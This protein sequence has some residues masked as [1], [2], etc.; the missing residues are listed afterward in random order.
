M[1]TTRQNVRHTKHGRA[2]ES[3]GSALY[4][5][6]AVRKGS[7][8]YGRPAESKGPDLRGSPATRGGPA[9]YG[10]TTTHTGFSTVELLIS[11]FIAAAFIATAFQLFFVVT[12]D[13]NDARRRAQAGSIVSQALKENASKVNDVCS[14]TPPLS[15]SPG[16][17]DFPNSLLMITYSCPYGVQSKTTRVT[18]SLSYDH[19]ST[20][21]K[22]VQGSLD[23][24]R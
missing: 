22:T 19:E 11:L 18:A 15:S 4:G 2:V 16:P 8:L 1:I 6:S 20:N 9:L 5:H 21:F 23:V 7:A 14:P 13:S 3:K 12:E 10:R 17:D 24:S